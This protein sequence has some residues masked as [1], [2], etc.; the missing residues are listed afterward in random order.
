MNCDEIN[1]PQLL[2][3]YF[4]QTSETTLTRVFNCFN[5]LFFVS[6]KKL[7]YKEVFS[8]KPFTRHK[9]EELVRDAFNDGLLSF[10]FFIREKGFESRGATIKT[11][12][13]E[14]CKNKLRGLIKAL[15]RLSARQYGGDPENVLERNVTTIFDYQALK[16]ELERMD[17]EVEILKEAFKLLGKRC[18]DLILWRKVDKISN[19]E[20]AKRI[21]IQPNSVNNEVFKCFRKLKEI[22]DRLK[23]GK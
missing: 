1:E 9:E 20:I 7:S 6:F 3:S 4:Q 23:R 2:I 12:F 19:E 22:A 5:T 16:E 11:L 10:Y 13:F 14:F 18:T 21:N 17:N 8:I 15:E